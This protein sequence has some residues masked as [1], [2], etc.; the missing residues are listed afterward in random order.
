MHV[1]FEI[2]NL[3]VHGLVN[4]VGQGLMSLLDH[5]LMNLGDQ[6]FKK[7]VFLEAHK[8]AIFSPITKQKSAKQKK[9]KTDSE[10][11]KATV[12]VVR[13]IQNSACESQDIEPLPE[14]AVGLTKVRRSIVKNSGNRPPRTHLSLR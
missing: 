7:K 9:T 4:L 14:P 8:A 3:V 2:V 11:D 10:A 12:T 13:N 5:G 6:N 1:C